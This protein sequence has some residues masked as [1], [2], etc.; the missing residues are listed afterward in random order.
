MSKK[1]LAVILD[2]PAGY[3]LTGEIRP[4]LK[5]EPN[6]TLPAGT[7]S[8]AAHDFDV[9]PRAIL[10]KVWEAPACIPAGCWVYLVDDEWYVSPPSHQPLGTDGT[11]FSQ[12]HG[13]R[14]KIVAQM[15]GQN[16]IPPTGT[17]K[18]QVER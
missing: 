1:T 10:R 4:P 6:L 13:V 14:A 7:F 15:Y 18:V 17:I 2:V 11:C 5:G 8:H 16:F 12:C 3:A 9:T